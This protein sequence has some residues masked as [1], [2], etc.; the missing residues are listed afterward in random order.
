M[1]MMPTHFAGTR[2]GYVY[3]G[4]QHVHEPRTSGTSACQT[5]IGTVP[6]GR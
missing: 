1:T 3:D 4:D 2:W 5:G 6:P